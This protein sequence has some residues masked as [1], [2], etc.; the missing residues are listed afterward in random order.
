MRVPRT[1]QPLALSTPRLRLRQVKRSDLRA[2]FNLASDEQVARFVLWKKHENLGDARVFLRALKQPDVVT[3]AIE[4]KAEPGLIGI[5]ILHSF[6]LR[7]KHLELAYNLAREHWGQ[8]IAA[9]AASRLVAHVFNVWQLNCIEATCMPENHRSIRVLE[10]LGMQ[11]EG[12]MR[13][14]HLRSEGDFV[15]MSLYSILRSEWELRAGS[16]RPKT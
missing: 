2:I 12:V 9:E 11:F 15:D 8:G 13:K 4:Q 10:K 3:W 14:S 5:V 16:Q 1:Y 7:H 6:N